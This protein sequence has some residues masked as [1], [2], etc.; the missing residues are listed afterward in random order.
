MSGYSY[1]FL[2]S[3]CSEISEG[4]EPPQAVLDATAQYRH[5]SDKL[6]R[7]VEDTLI[8]DPEGEVRTEELY[9]LYKDW[10]LE[11]GQQP[12]SMPGFRRG[13]AAI[14]EVKRKRPKGRR[15]VPIK[16]HSFVATL[17]R[18]KSTGGQVGQ[19]FIRPF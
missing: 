8:E 9:K 11:N 7:F 12:E 14:G 1:I 18:F 17:Y 15:N 19:A 3:A 6:A 13:L 5:D 2:I 10:C 16:A 4:F